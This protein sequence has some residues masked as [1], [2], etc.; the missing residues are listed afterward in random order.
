MRPKRDVQVR[1]RS[2]TMMAVGLGLLLHGPAMAQVESRKA[3][4][5]SL[6][7]LYGGA[8]QF[9]HQSGPYDLMSGRHAMGFGFNVSYG[10]KLGTGRTTLGGGL[11]YLRLPFTFRWDVHARE[12]YGVEYPSRKEGYSPERM[13]LAV[14]WLSCEQQL[15]L[16]H[17]APFLHFGFGFGWSSLDFYPRFG[18]RSVQ[19]RDQPDIRYNIFTMTSEHRNGFVPLVRLGLGK[20]WQ[21][22]NKNRIGVTAFVQWSWVDDFNSGT[23]LAYPG[24]SSESRGTW[25]QGL[26]Y[27]GLKAHY[28]LGFGPGKVPRHLRGTE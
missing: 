18:A 7:G 20:E 5:V 14:L 19:T 3:A 26:N 22:A 25:K 17:R 28:A 24:T 9:D 23:Y 12:V 6:V 8:V 2:A 27:I 1:K 13:G 16:D 10:Q 15:F 21:F 11:E 4:I